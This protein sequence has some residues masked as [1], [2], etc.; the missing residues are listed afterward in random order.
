VTG[1]RCQGNQTNKKS[2]KVLGCASKRCVTHSKNASHRL[3]QI[4]EAL[5][6]LQRLPQRSLHF[7]A[8]P[9][10]RRI[11]RG[12]LAFPIPTAADPTTPCAPTRL[13]PPSS[14]THLRLASS[15]PDAEELHDDG[16]PRW[17]AS[18]A[19]DPASLT[20]DGVSASSRPRTTTGRRRGSI[21]FPAV[22]SVGGGARFGRRPEAEHGISTEAGLLLLPRPPAALLG[23]CTR[24]PPSALTCGRR[25]GASAPY[26][27]SSSRRPPDLAWHGGLPATG[28][29]LHGRGGLPTPPLCGA[30][31]CEAEQERLLDDDDR[32]SSFPLLER[33]WGRARRR[34]AV[35]FSR[36]PPSP[37]ATSFPA[38]RTRDRVAH[39]L[40][41]PRARPTTASYARG[42]RETAAG[43]RHLRD[44]TLCI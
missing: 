25:G 17:Q 10:L 9:P 30:F 2:R 11:L 24:R 38:R 16:G 15:I 43:L 5:F 13:P 28:V 32:P 26:I 41:R 39:L 18:C 31:W 29:S 8:A 23:W 19:A 7:A 35:A 40:R 37:S 20:H 12:V 4:L 3:Q 22:D 34:L 33:P 1:F 27:V 21:R 44:G 6:H 14:P 36:P 42:E